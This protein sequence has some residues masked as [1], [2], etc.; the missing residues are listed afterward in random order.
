MR[1]KLFALWA[2][3]ALPLCVALRSEVLWAPWAL[4]AI[5]G[6]S[7]WTYAHTGHS[8]RVG[9]EDLRGHGNRWIAAI[10]LTAFLS[11]ALRRFTGAGAWAMRTAGHA[12]NHHDRQQRAGR[13]A[14][15]LGALQYWLG[16]VVLLVAIGIYALPET[17]DLYT[18]SAAA[19]GGECP[20]CR[21]GRAS[22]VR[23]QSRGGEIGI[24]LLLGLVAAGM[25]AG[26]V[27]GILRLAR[28][29]VTPGDDA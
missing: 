9:P 29:R 2:A 1:G 22:A 18:L 10:L 15:H 23:E 7:L 11:P 17:F 14:G 21:R 12:G 5:S 4:V 8:W 13:V 20:D 27:S 25:L 16:L 28:Q 19:L 3:L 24:L 26:S 6:I